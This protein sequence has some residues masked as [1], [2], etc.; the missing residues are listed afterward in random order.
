[1]ELLALGSVR[2]AGISSPSS[3]TSSMG[4]LS[5]LAICYSPFVI[6]YS[7]NASRCPQRVGREFGRK[8]N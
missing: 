3:R 7:R 1:M 4:I 5:L 2:R 6:R 8:W